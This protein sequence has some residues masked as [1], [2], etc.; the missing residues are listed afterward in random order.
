MFVYRPHV[1]GLEATTTPDLILDLPALSSDLQWHGRK[2]AV[3]AAWVVVAAGYGPL[4]TVGLLDGAA[5]WII[6]RQAWRLA[7]VRLQDLEILLQGSAA[8]VA[9]DASPPAPG[10][11]R[12]VAARIPALAKPQAC[13]VCLRDRR[14]G[15]HLAHSV[16]FLE[17]QP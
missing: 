9:G 6:S 12:F 4:L 8:P 14:L 17:K 2:D 13:E 7:D 16:Q 15:R 10:L 11:A 3:A 1:H 5:P